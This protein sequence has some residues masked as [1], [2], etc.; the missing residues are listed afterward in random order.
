[1][2]LR[3]WCKGLAAALLA[4]GLVVVSAGCGGRIDE[5]GDAPSSS[6]PAVTEPT[7]PPMPTAKELVEK[8]GEQSKGLHKLRFSFSSTGKIEML[9]T[10]T[11]IRIDSEMA[12]IE[13]DADIEAIGDVNLR[14]AGQTQTISFY[15]KDKTFYLRYMGD[16]IKYSIT[17]KDIPTSNPM[18]EEDMEEL[19]ALFQLDDSVLEDAVVTRQ[20][21]GYSVS[22]QYTPPL[23]DKLMEYIREA[24]QQQGTSLPEED[25]PEIQIDPISV[26]IGFHE[27]GKVTGAQISTAVTCESEMP[28]ANN[29]DSTVKYEIKVT[30]DS[31]VTFIAYGDDVVITPPND[32]DTFVE[33]NSASV[34]DLTI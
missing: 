22:M 8:A 18:T 32:L 27:D 15:M 2:K 14:F 24:A 12:L 6:M 1:M 16:K 10:T 9:D 5:P 30:A 34:P 33:A 13:Q 3:Q 31:N 20:G 23:F 28:D 21:D 11:T 7:E 26:Q 4:A 29:P 17:E 19:K 25:I